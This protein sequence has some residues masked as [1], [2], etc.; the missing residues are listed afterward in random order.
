MKILFLALITV[1]SVSLFA[2]DNNSRI[3]YGYWPVGSDM[4][5]QAVI[6]KQEKAVVAK[7][8]SAFVDTEQHFVAHTELLLALSVGLVACV[9]ALFFL[10]FWQ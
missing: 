9:P 10:D 4:I 8:D 1:W 7:E 6:P 5:Y 2:I 3:K